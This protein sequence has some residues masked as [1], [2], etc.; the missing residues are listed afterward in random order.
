LT[1]EAVVPNADGHLRAGHFAH[2]RIALE[3]TQELVRVPSGAVGER[4]GVERLFV[5]ED[6][7]ARARIVSTVRRDGDALLVSGEVHPSDA[8][9]TEP[10]RARADGSP[11]HV[12]SPVAER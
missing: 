10:P 5:I 7:V 11:V 2:A 6:G 3:G 4:A 1:I 9:V 12:S 8:V